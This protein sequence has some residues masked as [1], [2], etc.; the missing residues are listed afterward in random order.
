MLDKVQLEQ[1][2]GELKDPKYATEVAKTNADNIAAMLNAPG[3]ATVPT[4]QLSAQ[5]LLECIS[6]PDLDQFTPQ[7]LQYI[8]LVM[9]VGQLNMDNFKEATLLFPGGS[10]SEANFISKLTRPASRAEELFGRGTVVR[11]DDVGACL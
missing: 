6:I 3:S 4:E 10:T 7:Q 9:T 1:L 11:S 2:R 5:D 8:Q